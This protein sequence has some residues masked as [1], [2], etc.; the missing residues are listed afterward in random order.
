MI[1]SGA[2]VEAA[3]WAGCTALIIAAAGGHEDAVAMLLEKER[4]KAVKAN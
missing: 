4:T 1:D 2:E 3:D